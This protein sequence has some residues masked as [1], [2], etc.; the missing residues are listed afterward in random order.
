MASCSPCIVATTLGPHRRLM[1]AS[2]EAQCIAPE[3]QR[4]TF[5][6]TIRSLLR[7][8]T[9]PSLNR[10]TVPL[11]QCSCY[12]GMVLPS[13]CTKR[14]LCNIGRHKDSHRHRFPLFSPRTVLRTLRRCIALDEAGVNL[15]TCKIG[16]HNGFETSEKGQLRR[17]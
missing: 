5:L 6:T 2:P 13:S 15:L 4:D 9:R 14:Q 3:R 10:S 16:F 8:R 7:C 17:R 12:D 11:P 1:H